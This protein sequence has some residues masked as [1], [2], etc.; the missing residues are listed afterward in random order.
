LQ[1]ARKASRSASGIKIAVSLKRVLSWF[2][3]I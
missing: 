3:F 2:I 1:P